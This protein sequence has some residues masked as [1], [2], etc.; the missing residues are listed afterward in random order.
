MTP[1]FVWQTVTRQYSR[2]ATLT[3][4]G[5]GLAGLTGAVAPRDCAAFSSDTA[6][7]STF[8]LSGPDTATLTASATDPRFVLTNETDDAVRVADATWTVYH[9]GNGWEQVASDQ[10]S[11]ASV[12]LGPGDETAWAV[13]VRAE[14]AGY[15]TSTVAA[16]A[17][18]T[19]RY[20]GPVSLSPGTHA[21]VLSGRVEGERFEATARFDV[22]R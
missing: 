6:C 18:S 16:T 4:L 11:G 7:D 15:T 1:G 12:T 19:T 22:T 3:A 20:V 2:R 17:L 14:N 5:A 8:S 9:R 21:F 10:S 13:L